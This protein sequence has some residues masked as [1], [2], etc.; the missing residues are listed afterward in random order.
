MTDVCYIQCNKK[1]VYLS[2][3]KDVATG[4]IVGHNVSK[5]NNNQIY[6][7]TWKN[8]KR[9]YNPLEPKITHSDN[10]VQYTSIWA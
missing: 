7:D 5:F 3:L 2:V 8:A 9:F 10:G 4:F 6:Q 1:F